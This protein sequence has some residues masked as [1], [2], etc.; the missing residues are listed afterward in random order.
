M[1]FKRTF[2][3]PGEFYVMDDK[4]GRK[5]EF[6]N[7]PTADIKIKI[8][9]EEIALDH[10]YAVFFAKYLLMLCCEYSEDKLK[11]ERDS[12]RRWAEQWRDEYV[13]EVNR[14]YIATST[15]D[16]LLPWGRKETRGDAR[17]RGV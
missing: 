9:N 1:A 7:T 5:F 6:G 13:N 17:V 3:R 4:N 8:D 11:E 16:N 12:A 2:D 10:R 15:Q 14:R